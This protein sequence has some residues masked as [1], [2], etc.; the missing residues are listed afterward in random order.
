MAAPE[1]ATHMRR[2]R[3]QCRR[4][5]LELDL[6][7]EA[8]LDQGYAALPGDDRERFNEL[9]EYPDQL[10]Q[11]WLT[12]KGRPDDPAMGRLIDSIRNAG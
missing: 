9:L 1:T 5:L 3:W 6:L 7:F 10:L 8:F 12:G 4:G 11:E 2:L